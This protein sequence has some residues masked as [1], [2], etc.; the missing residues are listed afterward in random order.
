M[1]SPNL[2]HSRPEHLKQKQAQT[3]NHWT[4]IEERYL[5]H[6]FKA[7]REDAGCYAGWSDEEMPSVHEE[8]ALSL[9]L[10]KKAEKYGQKI[11][12]H[13]SRDIKKKYQK[14]HAAVV[15]PESIPDL[16]ISPF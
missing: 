15:W 1:A 13:A 7:A 16:D 11:A 14:D 8:Q 6:A 9:H 12:E 3:K 4:K 5:T 2:V 10:Y